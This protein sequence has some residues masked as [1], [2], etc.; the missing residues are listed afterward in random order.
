MCSTDLDLQYGQVIVPTCF[1]ER[2]MK[3]AMPNGLALTCG[4]L[5]SSSLDTYL[6]D[7]S[8]LDV[9]P[10]IRRGRHADQHVLHPPVFTE[11]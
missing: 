4:E 9:R 7:H 1:I 2:S 11:R 3:K 5:R 10:P 8:V 6:L